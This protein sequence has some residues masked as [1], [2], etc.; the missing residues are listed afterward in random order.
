MQRNK[1][2]CKSFRPAWR[3]AP[4]D[5][6]VV[7][8]IGNLLEDHPQYSGLC[9][10]IGLSG[11]PQFTYTIDAVKTL[12]HIFQARLSFH[13]PDRFVEEI[14]DFAGD[15]APKAGNYAGCMARYG[16]NLSKFFV[17]IATQPDDTNIASM[18]SI[19]HG[20]GHYAEDR[21]AAFL[22]ATST[23]QKRETSFNAAYQLLQ[24]TFP[25]ISEQKALRAAD[26]IVA[27]INALW[28]CWMLNL[29]TGLVLSGMILDEINDID[30]FN[31]FTL[32]HLPKMHKYFS[33][34]EIAEMFFRGSDGFGFDCLFTD[35]SDQRLCF[36]IDGATERLLNRLLNFPLT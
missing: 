24:D 36:Q 19:L 16:D 22:G 6:P 32:S 1:R 13:H 21:K 3:P 4:S 18:G 31:G 23:H 25:Q 28:I 11:L 5:S 9:R 20:F 33:D 14:R 27:W 34:R 8:L 15:R 30:H 26:E 7:L 2:T 10:L 12:G 35:G 17:A 29:D